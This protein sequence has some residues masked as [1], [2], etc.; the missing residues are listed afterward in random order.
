MECPWNKK[1]PDNC[2]RCCF[3]QFTGKRKEF[4][5]MESIWLCTYPFVGDV[6]YSKLA[7]E[8]KEKEKN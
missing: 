6:D 5:N 3:G 4:F 2:P 7:E 1:H 8:N